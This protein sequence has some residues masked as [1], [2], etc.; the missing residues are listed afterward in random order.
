MIPRMRKL[1]AALLMTLAW[2]SSAFGQCAPAPDSAYFFR[3]LSE[4]RAAAK[5]AE[6]RAY[7]EGLLSDDF[8]TRGADGRTLARREYIA[9]QLAEHHASAMRPF[10][11]I[12]NYTL[13]EHRKGYTVVSYEL[14]E[15]TTGNGQAQMVELQMREVYAVED[16]K[17]R[18]A[19][20]D[21][22]PLVYSG[23]AVQARR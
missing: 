6:D 17:W 23:P 1:A 8:T 13:V 22:A 19:A 20:V 7:F 18:L 10:F 5:I 15:G 16:G 3:D 2:Q 12:S 9:A 14:R 21:A 4:K 11:A